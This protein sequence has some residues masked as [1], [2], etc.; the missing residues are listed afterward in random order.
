MMVGGWFLYCGK[1][2]DKNHPMNHLG[3]FHP[4]NLAENSMVPMSETS[5][6]YYGN[7]LQLWPWL[8]VITGYFSGIIQS[9]N[10]VF[11]VLITGISG[12]NCMAL[13]LPS[14]NLSK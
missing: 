5:I 13:G 3:S 1:L 12:H 8:L 10:G 2:N 9:I 11:L 7:C 14:G 4:L 6:V